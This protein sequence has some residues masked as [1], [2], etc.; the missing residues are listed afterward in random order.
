MDAMLDYSTAL[1]IRTGERLTIVAKLLDQ[2]G[3]PLYSER[4]MILYIKSEDL[5]AF[6]AGRLTRDEAKL[7]IV[8]TRF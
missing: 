6:R 2:S 8:D 4:M 1:Q 3:N 7:K 5:A